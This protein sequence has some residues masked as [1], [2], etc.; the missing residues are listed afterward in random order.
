MTLRILVTVLLVLAPFRS[1]PAAAASGRPA[2]VVVLVVDQMRRDYIDDYGKPW[3]GGLRRLIDEGAWFT[4]A[5]YPYLAT[6]TCPGHATIST[7]TLP[8][9]HGIISNAWWDRQT[10]HFISCTSDSTSKAVPYGREQAGIGGSGR[11][12]A[13]PTL[14]S[15]LADAKPAGGRVVALSL[16]LASAAMLSGTKGNAVLWRQGGDWASSTTYADVPEKSLLRFIA[17]SPV[18]QDFGASWSRAGAKSGYKYEDKGV[19][20]KPPTEWTA[21]MPHQLQER[22][23]KPTGFFYEAWEESPFSDAYLGRLAGAAID[24][25]KLGQGPGTDYLAVSFSA[26]DI[27]GHD[28]GPRSHEV[29]DV[30]R[31]LDETVGKLLEQLDKKVGRD[32]YVVALTADHGVATIPEQ[33]TAEGADAGRVKMAEMMALVDGVVSKKFGRGRWVAIQAY[34]EFY[35]RA[36][37]FERIAA[38]PEL[39][40]EVMHTLEAQPGVQKVY[41]GRA[42]A[43][44]GNAASDPGAEAAAKSYF[45]G[46]SGDLLIVLKPNWIFVSD[47]K[48]VIPGNATTHGS[49]YAYDRDVPLVLFGAGVKPGR[50]EQPVSPADIAPTLARL[51]AVTLPTATGRVLEEAIRPVPSQ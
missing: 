51:C 11:L 37:V 42:L 33:L 19:G 28:F 43:S 24:G 38:D 34:S 21:E 3:T 29:Q 48:A 12:L 5:S 15:V 41:D 35:F 26:L 4:K 40:A 36:G 39:L 2:L 50:Y 18:E 9:T 14:A 45:R 10:Q 44:N 32:R 13:V 7:G 22:S 30:L 46:R 23:G 17:R 16:K 20:E 27:V 8:S 31:R 25:M 6:L 47:D 1:P 49:P